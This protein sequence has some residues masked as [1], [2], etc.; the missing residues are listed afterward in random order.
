[1]TGRDITEKKQLEEEKRRL[2]EAIAME[3]LKTE[4]FATVS[5]EFKTLLNIILTT[6]QLLAD[7][8]KNNILTEEVKVDIKYING[9]KQNSYRLLKLVN[10]LIDITQIDGGIYKLS[11]ENCNI[12]SII[13]NIVLSVSQYIHEKN[14]NIILD[15]TKEEIILAVDCDKIERIILN[16][17]S[18]AV[19]Y[20]EQ[21]GNIYVNLSTDTRNDRVIVNVKDDGIGIPEEDIERI[22]RRFKQSGDVFT[23]RC[24]GTGIGL[25]IV[26]SLIEMHG[27]KIT[28]NEEVKKGAEFIF[29]I[30]IN[31][32]ADKEFC[33]LYDKKIDSRFEKYNIEFSDIY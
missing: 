24:E 3:S 30:P 27:G 26:R 13:E 20:T 4:F 19:K 1:M 7:K 23:R 6:V 9:I 33:S 2:E 12:V 14:R 25:S 32:I 5:H 28:V 10:N 29:Y 16:L 21:G 11:L 8:L 18:N 17:L 15:T 31:K 22:F